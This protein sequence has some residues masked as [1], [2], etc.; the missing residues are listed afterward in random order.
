[1]NRMGEAPLCVLCR[2]RPWTSAG[3]R[4]AASGA[5]TKTWRG[6]PTGATGSP[7]TP[8]PSPDSDTDQDT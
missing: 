5:G 7:A 8:L 1:M 4:S 6:G 2:K 3:G